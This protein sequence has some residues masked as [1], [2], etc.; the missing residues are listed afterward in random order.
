MEHDNELTYLLVQVNYGTA[1]YG[2][3]RDSL[4]SLSIHTKAFPKFCYLLI[5]PFLT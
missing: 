4:I 5:F 3:A 2:T 1:H